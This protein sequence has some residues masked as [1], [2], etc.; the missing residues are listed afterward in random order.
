MINSVG[1]HVTNIR[2]YWISYVRK[3]WFKI[4]TGGHYGLTKTVYTVAKTV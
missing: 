2:H 3:T 1:I 4:A